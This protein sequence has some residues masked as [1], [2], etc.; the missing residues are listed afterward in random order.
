ML[1]VEKLCKQSWE[2]ENI[3][4]YKLILYKIKSKWVYKVELVKEWWNPEKLEC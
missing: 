4:W 1:K 3:R 2:L